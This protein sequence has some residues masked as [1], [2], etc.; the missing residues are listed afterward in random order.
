MAANRFVEVEYV[1]ATA[2]RREHVCLLV[3]GAGGARDMSMWANPAGGG[4][5]VELDEI[6]LEFGNSYGLRFW[7][8]RALHDLDTQQAERI[9]RLSASLSPVRQGV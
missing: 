3:H 9:A 1:A 5:V 6:L 2:T 4:P 7:L 8:S